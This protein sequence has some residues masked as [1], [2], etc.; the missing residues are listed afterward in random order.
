MIILELKELRFFEGKNLTKIPKQCMT[1]PFCNWETDECII[2]GNGIT[3]SIMRH[4]KPK[5]CPIISVK[6][7]ENGD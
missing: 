6:E 7:V 2:S 1:C 4:K 3:D 5:K